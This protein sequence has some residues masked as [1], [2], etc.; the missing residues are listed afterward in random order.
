MNNTMTTMESIRILLVVALVVILY[1]LIPTLVGAIVFATLIYFVW[2]GRRKT[3]MLEERI[4]QLTSQPSDTKPQAAGST[5][6][7]ST[8]A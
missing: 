1:I 7:T 3:R 5:T 4:A 6:P 8:D 2:Q